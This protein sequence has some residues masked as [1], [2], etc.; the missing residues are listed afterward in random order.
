[1]ARFAFHLSWLALLAGAAAPVWGE[2]FLLSGGG[3]IEGRLINAAETPRETY[4]I[5][6]Q[7]GGTITLIKAQVLQV[8]TKSPAEIEYDALLPRVTNDA[9][10]HWKMAE[11]C[12]KHDGMERQRDFHM[13]R[14]IELDPE[15][16]GAR[17]GLGYTQ[18]EGKWVKPDE[19]ME[20][21][22]YVRHNGGWRTLNEVALE[23][24]KKERDQTAKDWKAKI[25]RWV[26]ALDQRRGAEA[27]QE[28]K[29]VRDPVAA[30]ALGELLRQEGDVAVRKLYVDMLSRLPPGAATG[31]LVSAALNDND[32]QVRDLAVRQLGIWG[33][34]APAGLVQALGGGRSR[35]DTTLINRAGVA[36][37]HIQDPETILPLIDALTTHKK[38]VIQSGSPGGIGASF[39][40]GGS[41]LSSG[42]SQKVI[43]QDVENQGVLGALLQMSGGDNYRFDRNAWRRW[44][45]EKAA[46]K[47]VNLRR[48]E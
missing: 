29:G 6:T 32:D 26:K 19:H 39:G 43:E 20:A 13:Q 47:R 10:A 27:L 28:L 40:T 33:L 36:L 3:K 45:A 41:G 23:T 22:G 7:Q 15:H 1:M 17:R 21:L 24:A 11:W 2:T 18:M 42:S 16:D 38:T 9:E 30:I 14:V 25:G 8:M 4:V 44:Y 5:R 34:P 37:A 35:D 48:D 46:P 12:R 31:P